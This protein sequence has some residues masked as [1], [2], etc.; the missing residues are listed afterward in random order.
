MEVTSTIVIFNNISDAEK[1]LDKLLKE[2]HKRGNTCTKYSDIIE[3][4]GEYGITVLDQ[5]LKYLSSSDLTKTEP[6][7][8]TY[9]LRWNKKPN[10]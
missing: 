10:E 1:A 5:D 8:K 9:D 2:A 7:S 4:G 6:K 3:D